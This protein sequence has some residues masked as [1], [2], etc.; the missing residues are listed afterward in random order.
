MQGGR[1]PTGCFRLRTARRSACATV[2]LRGGSPRAAV[3]E[4]EALAVHFQD[5]DMMGETVEQRPGQALRAER[6]GP[7][8]EGKV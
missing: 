4:A 1:S 8:I 3:V 5:M 6:L 7:F 2:S